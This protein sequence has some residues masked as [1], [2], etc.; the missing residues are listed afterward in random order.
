MGENKKCK[1]IEIFMCPK[2]HKPIASY[3]SGVYMTLLSVIQG[4]ALAGIFSIIWDYIGPHKLDQSLK[5]K[6]EGPNA[7]ESVPL[8]CSHALFHEHNC[9]CTAMHRTRQVWKLRRLRITFSS[10]LG[11]G[12]SLAELA[13]RGSTQEMDVPSPTLLSAQIRPP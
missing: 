9:S 1:S 4:M 13:A 3:F 6:M 12:C 10:L 11:Y 7:K 5:C 8:P 2:I